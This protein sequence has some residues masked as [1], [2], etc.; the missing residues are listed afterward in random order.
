[1]ERMDTM[2]LM[3]ATEAFSFVC[4]GPADTWNVTRILLPAPPVQV[5]VNGEAL[6]APWDEASKTCFLRFP[7]SPEGVTVEIG[8]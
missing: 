1:M 6:Q 8:W 5:L 7:N 3:R 4:K 2:A